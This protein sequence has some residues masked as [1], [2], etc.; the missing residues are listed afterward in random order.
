MNCDRQINRKKTMRNYI[1][2]YPSVN[3]Y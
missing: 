2:G 3:N 1:T